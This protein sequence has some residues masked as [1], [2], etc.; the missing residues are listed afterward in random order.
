MRISESF[1]AAQRATFQDKVIKHRPAVQSTGSL[2]SVT[3][4][5]G[6]A[7]ASYQVN[8]QLISDALVAQEWGLVVAQD[9][10]VTC[11]DPLHVAN[12]DYVQY[13]DKVYKVVGKPDHDSHSKLMLKLTAEKAVV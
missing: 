8:F 3:T 5:P 11:S 4:G 12:G 10:V 13:K 9:A 1:K 7:T 6:A 2:G